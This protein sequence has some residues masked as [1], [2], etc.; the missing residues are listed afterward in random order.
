MEFT[1]YTQAWLIVAFIVSTELTY[2]QISDSLP[3]IPP[4]TTTATLPVRTT[5]ATTVETEDVTARSRKGNTTVTDSQSGED[6]RGNTV[7]VEVVVAGVIICVA[8]VIGAVLYYKR[9]PTQTSGVIF[10][11]D[12]EI[13]SISYSDKTQTTN[14]PLYANVDVPIPQG[15]RVEKESNLREED[16]DYLTLGSSQSPH[17]QVPQALERG[18]HSYSKLRY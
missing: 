6:C 18:E 10:E 16:V 9:R 7:I 3:T 8:M 2:A 5:E 1:R 17:Y 13:P 14:T 15:Q 4:A 12:T 11:N